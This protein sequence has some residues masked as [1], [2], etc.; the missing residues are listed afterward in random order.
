MKRAVKKSKQSDHSPE[1]DEAM[2]ADD[3]SERRDCE[4]CDNETDGPDSGLIRDVG[5]RIRAEVSVQTI[6]NKE[7]KGR[8]TR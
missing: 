3:S 5:D 2:Q 4:S 6:P 8:E 7:H 1:C